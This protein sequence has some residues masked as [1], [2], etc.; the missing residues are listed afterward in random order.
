MGIRRVAIQLGSEAMIERI[1]CGI[2]GTAFVVAGLLKFQ[3]PLAFEKAIRAMHLV[4]NAFASAVSLWLPAFEILCGL[5]VVIGFGRRPALLGCAVLGVMFVLVLGLAMS[6]GNLAG[7]GCFGAWDPFAKSPWLSLG[8]AMAFF[9]LAT[10]LYLKA[11]ANSLT[12]S[13]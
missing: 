2:L 6:R 12:S 10:G 5:L 4:P 7:C 9:F 8:R 3:N 13:Q 11:V 1:L